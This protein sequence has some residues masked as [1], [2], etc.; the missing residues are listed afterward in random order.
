[1]KKTSFSLL[2]AR[3][4]IVG[5]V[6]MAMPATAFTLHN[7]QTGLCLG[8]AGG[9]P[10]RGTGLV[11]WTCDGT[12]SQQWAQ[13]NYRLVYG[14]T[15]SYRSYYANVYST[16]FS[17]EQSFTLSNGLATVAY[18]GYALLADYSVVQVVTGSSGVIGVKGAVMSNGTGLI[19]YTWYGVPDQQ[20]KTVFIGTDFNG[21]S[22]YAFENADS[23]PYTPP[24]VMGVLGGKPG[25]GQPVVIWR[26]FVDQY[27][28]PDYF[29]HPDQYWCVYY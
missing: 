4:A 20:W 28:N 29:G 17:E 1:M 13:I 19:L 16:S 25:T 8:V 3:L 7:Y 14:Y 12:P 23:S 9:N 10:K 26:E 6:A 11:T 21:N 27:E 5:S 2:I 24:Y 15:D 18:D 22:C